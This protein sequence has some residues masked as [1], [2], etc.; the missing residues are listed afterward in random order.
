VVVVDLFIVIF[1]VSV[2]KLFWS[3]LIVVWVVGVEHRGHI[4]KT[5][6]DITHVAL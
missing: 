3:W 5:V 6:T 1:L 4:C 2:D